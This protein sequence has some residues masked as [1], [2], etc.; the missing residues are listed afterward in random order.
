MLKRLIAAA[1]ALC[2]VFCIPFSLA[3]D[4]DDEELFEEEFTDDE[5]DE[6]F[7]E[8]TEK[9]DFRTISGYDI[10]TFESGGFRYQLTDDGLGAI[11]VSYYGTDS[12]VAFPDTLDNLPVVAINTAMCVNNSII[13]TLH[14][15]GSVQVIGPRAFAQCPN[16][17]SVEIFEGLKTL[18]KCCFGGCPE[19][20]EILL[21]DSLEV[22]DDF[23]FANCP[24][25]KAI[26]FGSN[27]QSIGRQAFQKCASLSTVT[28]PGGEAVRIGEEAFGECPEDLRIIY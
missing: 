5:L 12:D 22:I 27:L 28:I 20:K 25:L 16:L 1:L 13:Q 4:A 6:G 2:F 21:P 9:I 24:K 17:E 11:L 26:S 14:I 18:D 8:E 10:S 3:D 23:V 19:L 7:E 15:P